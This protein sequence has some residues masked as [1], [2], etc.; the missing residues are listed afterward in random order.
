MSLWS[1]V[2]DNV[3]YYFIAGK[4]MDEVIAGYRDLTGQAPM[5]GKWAYGYWQSKEHYATRDEL[6]G[7]AKE[8]RKRQI[9][10]D[11]HLFRTGITGAAWLIGAG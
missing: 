6:L 8:Y 5:Y 10:I 9:P 2:A 11:K 4:N 3:D 7:V 1:E